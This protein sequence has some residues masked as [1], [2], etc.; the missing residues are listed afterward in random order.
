MATH[1]S[2]RRFA[3]FDRYDS[4]IAAAIEQQIWGVAMKQGS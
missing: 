1:V 4:P 3:I 2:T